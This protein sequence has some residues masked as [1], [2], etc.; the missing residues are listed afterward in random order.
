[1]KIDTGYTRLL[2][3]EQTVQTTY[4]SVKTINEH[5]TDHIKIMLTKKTYQNNF[6][7][8]K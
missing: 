6:L 7:H 1:M 8:F 5:T 3:K 4:C 2:F